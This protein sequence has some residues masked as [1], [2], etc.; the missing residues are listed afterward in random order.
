M[1]ARLAISAIRPLSETSRFRKTSN[2][3]VDESVHE[4][5]TRS[6]L[7]LNYV[8][9]VG[10]SQRHGVPVDLRRQFKSI[11]GTRTAANKLQNHVSSLDQFIGPCSVGIQSIISESCLWICR[12]RVV[13]NFPIVPFYI[14]MPVELFFSSNYK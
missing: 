3:D 13:P 6:R 4:L 2:I 11:S 9:S 14:P 5:P 10:A 8:A 1:A 12:C 7:S